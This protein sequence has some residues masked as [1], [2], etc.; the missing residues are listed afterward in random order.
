MKSKKRFTATFVRIVAIVALL[1]AVIVPLPAQKAHA[2]SK[3][4]KVNIAINGSLNI[5]SIIKEKGLLD[6]VLKKYNATVTWS[7]FVGGPPI[8]EAL[9]AK[10]VDISVLGDGA[11]LQGLSAGLPFSGIGLVS[12][13]TRLNS[14]LVAP[15][16]GIATVKDLKGKTVAVAK[17]TTSHVFLVKVLAK[18]GL[19]EKDVK[20]V[21]LAQPE[22][23]SA[24]LGG[25]VDVWATIDPYTTQLTLQKKAVSIAGGNENISAPITLIARNA[26]AKAHP[27]IVTDILV[28]YKQAVNWQNT[29]TDEAAQLFADQKK[30]PKAV[31]K[32]ILS[33][34]V[35]KLSPITPAII[36]TQQK[37][38]DYLYDAKFLKK[39]IKYSDSVNNAFVTKA[40]AP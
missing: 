21:N 6:D 19:K 10:R 8:L 38:A 23:Q 9:A 13:G 28:V 18:Y 24:F 7:E 5:L 27:D 11:A 2:E 25:K 37:S 36:S 26:F 1:A 32:A 16:S 12:D 15:D 35:A 40:L 33:N 3:E 34:Q 14:I 30:I 39:K 22:A 20:I 31:V 4:I 29:H 17:G